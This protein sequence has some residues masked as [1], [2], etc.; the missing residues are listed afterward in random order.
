[1]SEI[2]RRRVL[3][4]GNAVA[5]PRR[6]MPGTNV[7]ERERWRQRGGSNAVVIELV[8]ILEPQPLKSKELLDRLN[9]P[10]PLTPKVKR[11][12][13]IKLQSLAGLVSRARYGFLEKHE[14]KTIDCDPAN[15]F[16][17]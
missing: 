2:K 3:K 7:A 12:P 17:Y 15:E 1:M 5:I 14:G 13:P 10:D 6:V 11:Y 9:T 16:E 4:S 8:E